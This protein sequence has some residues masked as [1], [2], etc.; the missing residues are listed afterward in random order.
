MKTPKN[1]E[2]LFV[3]GFGPIVCDPASSRKYYS[4]P[5]GLEFQ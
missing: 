5:L 3:A 4:E 2:V 1:I